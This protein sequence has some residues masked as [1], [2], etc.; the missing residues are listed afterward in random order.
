M[1]NYLLKIAIAI[2]YVINN[3][4]IVLL[5]FPNVPFSLLH[6]DRWMTSEIHDIKEILKH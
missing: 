4:Y 2:V 5:S 1:T 6:G 3:Q